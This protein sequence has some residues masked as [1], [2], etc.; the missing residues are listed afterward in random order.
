MEPEA[1]KL[2]ERCQTR[3][4]THGMIPFIGKVPN[5]QL[6][7][8]PRKWMNGCFRLRGVRVREWGMAANGYRVAFWGTECSR[9]DGG[10][11]WCNS[12][13]TFKV[14]KCIL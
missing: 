2:S 5:R 1:T 9:M 6:S 8:G 10:G 7:K 13:N 14:L 3:K 12:G 11:G 4:A